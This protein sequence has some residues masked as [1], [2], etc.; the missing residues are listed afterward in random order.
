M[1]AIL[2]AMVTAVKTIGEDSPKEAGEGSPVNWT[3]IAQ[4]RGRKSGSAGFKG[5]K[6]ERFKIEGVVRKFRRC[7]ETKYDHSC[8]E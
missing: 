2:G 7:A 6:G 3:E 1:G 8:K 4:Q 5:A